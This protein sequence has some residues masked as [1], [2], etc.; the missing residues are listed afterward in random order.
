[1]T[2]WLDPVR[3]AL[4][5]R[6]S[7]L[8][9]FIRDDDGGWGNEQLYELLA[10]TCRYGVPVDVAII[11]DAA[12]R[13]LAGELRRFDGDLVT[14]HQHGRAHVNHEAAG[15]KCEF[16]WSRSA[17]EQR[18]DIAAGRDRLRDAIGD[19]VQP[20]F[21]PPWNRCTTVTARCLADLGFELLSCDVTAGRFAVD[22]LAELPVWLDWT[23][24]HGANAGLPAWG[25]RIAGALE[26]AAAPVG[27]MLHHA[28]MTPDDRQQLAELLEALT[29]HRAVGFGS[30]LALSRADGQ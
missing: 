28:V 25:R 13:A 6:T 15:R 17:D 11:P 1:M 18:A 24:R 27:L 22:R 2:A 8:S 19:R 23:G 26:A 16:G 9:M 3:A 4:D 12:D 10:T 21:T 5:Q 29:A 20:M 30:M 7:P 14:V